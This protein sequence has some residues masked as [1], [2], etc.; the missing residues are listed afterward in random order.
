MSRT[1]LFIGDVPLRI[2][3]QPFLHIKPLVWSLKK[4]APELDISEATPRELSTLLVNDQLDCALIPLVTVLRHPELSVIP[5][6]TVSSFGPARTSM[7]FSKVAPTDIKTILVDQSSINSI[8]L[9]RA[10]FRIR[11]SMQPLEVL[12]SHPLSPDYPFYESDYDAFHIIG[13]QALKVTTEFPRE[14]DLGEQWEQWTH[15]PLVHAVWAVRKGLLGP[16]LNRLLLQAKLQGLGAMEEIVRFGHKELGFNEDI[17]VDILK[18]TSYDLTKTHIQGIERF[19]FYMSAV[20]I[21][22][23]SL[24]MKFY[25]GDHILIHK[26]DK[27]ESP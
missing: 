23:S 27:Q 5:G 20:K 25:H 24:N 6:I 16:P 17:C 19:H 1:D 14:I 9:I 26:I 2:G 11:W 8:A 21:C 18:K 12:S 7:I 4:L 10:L 22:Q 3:I 13:D 15:T